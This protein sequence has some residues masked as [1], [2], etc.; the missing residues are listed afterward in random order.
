ML[1]TQ[2]CHDTTAGKDIT[3][4]GFSQF[5]FPVN[6]LLHQPSPAPAALQQGEISEYVRQAKCQKR[7][8][9]QVQIWGME[10]TNGTRNTS[11]T[12]I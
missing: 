7:V 9:E 11:K 1:Q 5:C 12:P 10:N 3:P 2:S 4:W 6:K 8:T